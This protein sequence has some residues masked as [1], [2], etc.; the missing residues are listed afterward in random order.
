[1]RTGV[2]RINTCFGS[3]RLVY[4]FPEQRTLFSL[5]THTYLTLIWSGEV[6]V[7][8]A[9]FDLKLQENLL[10]NFCKNI[11]SCRNVFWIFLK[12]WHDLKKCCFHILFDVFFV[13][14][15]AAGPPFWPP[16]ASAQ[17]YCYYRP[18]KAGEVRPGW[19]LQSGAAPVRIPIGFWSWAVESTRDGKFEVGPVLSLLLRG[20]LAS[21]RFWACSR[22]QQTL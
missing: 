8:H 15:T 21:H 10:S 2:P 1:M 11:Y 19:S 16:L 5:N 4:F 3:R 14:S 12:F 17:F 13:R 6:K 7:D 9:D 18:P 20:P 22:N